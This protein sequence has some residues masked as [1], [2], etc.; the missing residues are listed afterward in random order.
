MFLFNSLTSNLFYLGFCSFIPCVSCLKIS[1]VINLLVFIGRVT[2]TDQTFG[3]PGFSYGLVSSGSSPI[4]LFH[5]PR[6][7]DHNILVSGSGRTV[8]VLSTAVVPFHKVPWAWLAIFSLYWFLLVA[9]ARSV[10]P[11]AWPNTP[12]LYALNRLKDNNALHHRNRDGSS[13]W[14]CIAVFC[15]RAKRQYFETI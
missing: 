10:L 12:W 8:F 4:L 3:L 2:Y 1:L 15:I 7:C 9:E 6:F 13:F 11:T 5:C 14:I